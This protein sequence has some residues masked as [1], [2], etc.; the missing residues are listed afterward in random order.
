M[1]LQAVE[2]GNYVPSPGAD[3]SEHSTGE[4]TKTAYIRMRRVQRICHWEAKEGW[5]MSNRVT[6]ENELVDRLCWSNCEQGKVGLTI[7]ISPSYY[8]D[9]SAQTVNYCTYCK[10][11]PSP[12]YANSKIH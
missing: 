11:Y 5:E 1:V 6:N 10:G 4:D 8:S 2:T 3:E 12:E 7:F 9:Y